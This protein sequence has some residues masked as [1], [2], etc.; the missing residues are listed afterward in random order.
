MLFLCFLTNPHAV[1]YFM[2]HK[3]PAVSAMTFMGYLQEWWLSEPFQPEVAT[4]R[5]T[6]E[7]NLQEPKDEH[8]SMIQKGGYMAFF[9]PYLHIDTYLCY[10][11][12]P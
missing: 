4:A 6:W 7:G 8:P 12:N 9:L 11:T 10:F 5:D 1:Q 2:G 3:H